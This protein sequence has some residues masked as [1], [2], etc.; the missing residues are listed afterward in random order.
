MKIT[1]KI[2][3]IVTKLTPSDFKTYYQYTVIKTVLTSRL[4]NSSMEQDQGSKNISA[5]TGSID[6]YKAPALMKLAFN[7]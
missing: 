2:K 5:N 7:G 3:N 6:F 4:T 1:L